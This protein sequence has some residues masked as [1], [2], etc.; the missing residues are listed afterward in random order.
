[1]KRKFRII[2]LSNPANA[3]FLS[4]KLDEK[5]DK[6]KNII[7]YSPPETAFSKLKFNK[8][9][10]KEL[11]YLPFKNKILIYNFNFFLASD[12]INL[13]SN[14]NYETF[15]NSESIKLKLFLKRKN[16]N[17]N[18]I[19]ELWFGWSQLKFIFFNILKENN[20]KYFKFDH[21]LGDIRATI[22]ELK[23]KSTYLKKKIKE[24]IVK[25]YVYIPKFNYVSLFS[26]EIK[27]INNNNN[28]RLISINRKYYRK[29]LKLCENRIK[30][31]SLKKKLISNSIVIMVD[32]ICLTQK[33]SQ[34]NEINNFFIELLELIEK[35][36]SKK[37]A[38]NR[39][40]NIIIKTKLHNNLNIKYTINLLKKRYLGKFNIYLFNELIDGNYNIEYTVGLLNCKI[41]AST[42]SS[43]QLTI[44]KIE[45][46]KIDNYIFTN[47][48]LDFWKNKGK[49]DLVHHDFD[50]IYNFFYK[51]YYHYFKNVIPKTF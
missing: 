50:W 21:G 40:K 33:K 43:G 13:F 10:H 44:Q 27:K 6:L 5:R 28:Y 51:T 47:W 31:R 23:K 4:S 48:Y 17:L 37:I 25:H 14:K 26:D 41:I 15:Y 8:K 39:I 18:D 2:L 3:L 1:M 9:F 22:Y 34:N 12:N 20:C 24:L 42:F 7:I 11:C 29:N 45:G 19:S 35:K 16:I 32:Y 30:E 49:S 36:L 46:S 38:S